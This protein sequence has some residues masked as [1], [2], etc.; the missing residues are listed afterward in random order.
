MKSKDYSSPHLG[1]YIHLLQRLVP[2]NGRCLTNEEVASMAGLSEST[3]KRVKKGWRRTCMLITL[4]CVSTGKPALAARSFRRIVS[5][6]VCIA[7]WKPT[8]R[9]VFMTDACM[10][11]DRLL[12]AL[13][14]PFCDTL[15]PRK[16]NFL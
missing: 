4:Y 5:T 2:V 1:E 7:V 12:P 8:S 15:A 9:L 14:L 3:C 13:L 10:P 16:S 6:P 11:Q